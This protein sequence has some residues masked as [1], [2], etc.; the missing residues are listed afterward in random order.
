MLF[1]VQERRSR[2]F[3]GRLNVLRLENM[4]SWFLFALGSALAQS[5]SQALSNKAVQLGQYSKVTLSFMTTATTSILM[6]AVTFLF[7]GVPELKDGFWIAVLTTGAL[8]AVMIP[9]GFKAFELG[10]FSTV[11]SMALTTPI[12]LLFTGWIFLG[13]VPPILGMVGVVLTVVGL[14]EISKANSVENRAKDFRKGNLLA[15][16]V[17][18][19][20]SISVNFDKLAAVRSGPVFSYAVILGI[21]A[22]FYAA[23]LLATKGSIIIKT[24]NH[25]QGGRVGF[26]AGA[27]FFILLAGAAQ[28]FNG[29]FYNSALIIGL[30]SYTSAVKRVGILF[31]VFWGW[32]FFKEENIGEKI[33]GAGIAIL[34]VI[35]ILFS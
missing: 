11:Y 35:L 31:G 27:A 12:F 9:L 13:E 8:N 7:L 32:L 10:E 21:L 23:Y 4:L 16:A 17:A 18:L 33:L 25:N 19:M 15:L 29:F 20:A 14:W 34:G 2:I 5:A 6:F 3:L 22:V 28:A 1:M 26:L 24:E 30:A